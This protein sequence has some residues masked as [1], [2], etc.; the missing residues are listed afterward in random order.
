[1]GHGTVMAILG[2]ANRRR[3]PCGPGLSGSVGESSSGGSGPA[4]KAR[5]L[6]L[7]PDPA[8][9]CSKRRCPDSIRSTAYP[10]AKLR[11]SR[12]PPPEGIAYEVL[13]KTS[14]SLRLPQ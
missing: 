13:G 9:F 2:G 3:Y 8:H 5:C 12:V 6:T 11:T 4:D 7:G 1:M 14:R 10:Q